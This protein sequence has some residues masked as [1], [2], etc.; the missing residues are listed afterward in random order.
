MFWALSLAAAAITRLSAGRRNLNASAEWVAERVGNAVYASQKSEAKIQMIL[1]KDTIKEN[2][3]NK[4]R[5]LAA[6]FKF[7]NQLTI[8]I[9]LT[10]LVFHGLP[11]AFFCFT[12][13]SFF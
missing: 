12:H 13:R 5:N 10:F 7:D 2:F 6:F 1:T 9:K 3:N 11:R 8:V 4:I